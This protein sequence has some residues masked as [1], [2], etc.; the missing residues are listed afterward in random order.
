MELVQIWI[1]VLY[2]GKVSMAFAKGTSLENLLEVL[3]GSA[4]IWIKQ[5]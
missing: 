1:A 4:G 5:I 2:L 3:K